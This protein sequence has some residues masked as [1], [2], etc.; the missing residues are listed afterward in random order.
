MLPL[1]YSIQQPH[2]EVNAIKKLCWWWYQKSVASLRFV[3]YDRVVYTV[4]LTIQWPSFIQSHLFSRSRSERIGQESRGNVDERDNGKDTSNVEDCPLDSSLNNNREIPK[5]RCNTPLCCVGRTHERKQK[6]RKTQTERKEEK[7][8]RHK[9]ATL[10]DLEPT[11]ERETFEKIFS[12]LCRYIRQ[13]Y[14]TNKSRQT[15]R[16]SCY[17]K[18]SSSLAQLMI[19]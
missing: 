18:P 19:I 17:F 3:L 7:N 11:R 4:C 5:K 10:R 2:L 15:S 12:N 1:I 16:F 8:K 6:D 9:R 14:R 13:V